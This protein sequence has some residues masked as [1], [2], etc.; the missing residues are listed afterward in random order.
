LQGIDE[1]IGINNWKQ[2]QLGNIET[3]RA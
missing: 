2:L 1:K 3:N